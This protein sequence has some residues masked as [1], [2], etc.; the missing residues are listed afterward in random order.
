MRRTMKDTP[1]L[2]KAVMGRSEE[3][4][5]GIL[6]KLEERETAKYIEK[7]ESKGY[8]VRKIAEEP[9]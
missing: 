6:K 8:S 3:E 9:V 4:L 5:R 2:T 1:S 7:L